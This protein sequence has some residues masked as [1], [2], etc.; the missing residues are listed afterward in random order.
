MENIILKEIHTSNFNCDNVSVK[1][2][3][4]FVYNPCKRLV[5]LYRLY[6]L[7]ETL[8]HQFETEEESII[9]VDYA[10][11]AYFLLIQYENKIRNCDMKPEYEIA[12]MSISIKIHNDESGEWLLWVAQASGHREVDM[13]DLLKIEID[14]LLHLDHLYMNIPLPAYM[15]RLF[16]TKYN[17]DETERDEVRIL[18]MLSLGHPDLLEKI[19]SIS[20][21]VVL[22]IISCI[23]DNE[24]FVEITQK[25]I[26]AVEINTNDNCLKMINKIRNWYCKFVL[27]ASRCENCNNFYQFAIVN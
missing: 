9:N 8:N 3:G 25:L 2:N 20:K 18:F 16:T 17:L 11:L 13:E 27:H 1:K 15:I 23:I 10:H 22:I 26:S 14:L 4:I 5:L 6:V 12:A 24:H 21:L 7:C 19:G